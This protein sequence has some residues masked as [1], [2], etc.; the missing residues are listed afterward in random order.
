MEDFEIGVYDSE[1]YY[2]GKLEEWLE[3][4]TKQYKFYPNDHSTR[5]R[6]AEALIQ[7]SKNKEALIYLKK[8]HD[9]DP[10]DTEFN[11]QIID[12]LLKLG[13]KKEDFN[14]KQIPQTLKLDEHLQSEIISIMKAKRKRKM[15]LESVYIDLMS[16]VLEFT[17]AELMNYLRKSGALKIDGVKWYEAIIERRK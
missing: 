8:F 15:K 14:W 17:E 2:S 13:K 7:N 10:T 3:F 16:E 5:Y 6:F 12:A 1:L 11:Q 9:D 4:R